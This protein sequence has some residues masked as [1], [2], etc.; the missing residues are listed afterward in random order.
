MQLGAADKPQA[1]LQN[2]SGGLRDTKAQLCYLDSLADYNPVESP[3][4][5]Y[6]EPCWPSLSFQFPVADGK[7]QREREDGRYVSPCGSFER[8]TLDVYAND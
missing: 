4:C 5:C 1:S 8:T 7:P 2:S 3:T 6:P